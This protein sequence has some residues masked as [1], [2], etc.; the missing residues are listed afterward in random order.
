MALT[1]LICK[2]AVCSRGRVF[3]HITV[4]RTPY[5]TSV[6]LQA[7]PKLDAT[8]LPNKCGAELVTVVTN[9]MLSCATDSHREWFLDHIEAT[10]VQWLFSFLRL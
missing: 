7:A 5:K 2:C 4:V 6:G 3:G 1:R 8:A 9:S 10:Q